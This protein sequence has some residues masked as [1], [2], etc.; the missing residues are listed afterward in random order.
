MLEV[1][2]FNSQD[3]HQSRQRSVVPGVPA[4][5]EPYVYT[6]SGDFIQFP[7]DHADLA[8][9]ERAAE[10]ARHRLNS[11]VSVQSHDSLP[12]RQR[13]VGSGRPR[14]INIDTQSAPNSPLN[15]AQGHVRDRNN[16]LDFSRLL[17]SDVRRHGVSVPNVLTQSDVTTHA[18]P[19]IGSGRSANQSVRS[20]EQLV[21]FQ[22]SINLTIGSITQEAD[23][24]MRSNRTAQ[25]PGLSTR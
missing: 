8:L 7:P 4:P 24:I 21:E 3:Q 19:R 23:S 6:S 5:P 2:G 22:P 10:R 20:A 9:I 11:P 14:A 1:S 25:H 12:D 13:P 15:H 18:Q 16:E 17:L